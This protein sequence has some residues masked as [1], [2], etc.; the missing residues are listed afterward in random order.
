MKSSYPRKPS[1][2]TSR[3]KFLGW[4]DCI[5]R[6]HQTYRKL[7][8]PM[9]EHFAHEHPDLT[10]TDT[11]LI[12][13]IVRK[14]KD[15]ADRR[16]AESI[17]IRDRMPAINDNSTSWQLLPKQ[18]SIFQELTTLKSDCVDRFHRCCMRPNF[19]QGMSSHSMIIRSCMLIYVYNVH[20][21][22]ICSFNCFAQ[23]KCYMCPNFV[24]GKSVTCCP[25]N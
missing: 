2:K 5:A 14:C 13:R 9:G 24:Q 10:P 4:L 6:L 11:T 17:T 21:C 15:E 22:I 1:K 3:A 18:V 8:T 25:F 12:A 20:L 16:I 19:V 23:C 7:G